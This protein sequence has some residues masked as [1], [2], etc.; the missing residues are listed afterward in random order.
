[1]RRCLSILLFAALVITI[2]SV[3]EAD[4][5]QNEDGK[6]YDGTVASKMHDYYSENVDEN[7]IEGI[8]RNKRFPKRG[9]G[10]GR[11]GSTSSSSKGSTYRHGHYYSGGGRS[12]TPKP[13]RRTIH[14]KNSRKSA[15]MMECKG[16][17]EK[18]GRLN[19]IYP[20]E[21]ETFSF[22]GSTYV[23]TALSDE[24]LMWF[25]AYGS[26][27]PSG[28]D[29]SYDITDNGLKRDGKWIRYWITAR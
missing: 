3:A 5:E 13:I 2:P 10:G 27:A 1:M 17:G 8:I 12:K 4:E 15:V 6:D 29:L 14:F 28:S 23:C 11:R 18:S 20:G 7:P 25:P 21:T 16:D 26:D 22:S 19:K 9:G 24:K